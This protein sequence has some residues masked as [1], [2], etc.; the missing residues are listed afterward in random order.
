[1]LDKFLYGDEPLAEFR[2]RVDCVQ[3]DILTMDEAVLDG[4]EVV[5]HLAGLSNDPTAEFNPAANRRLNTDA[6]ARLATGAG[7]V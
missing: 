3:G 5:I 4:V 2:S 7:L 6:T 1:M